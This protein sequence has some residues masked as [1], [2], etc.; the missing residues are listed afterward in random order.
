MILHE[1]AIKYRNG[2]DVNVVTI[3][4]EKNL[5]LDCKY[6]LEKVDVVAKS[7]NVLSKTVVLYLVHIKK[8]LK[9]LQFFENRDHD[10]Q[11]LVDINTD[12][13]CCTDRFN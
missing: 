4:L 9:M 7:L 8:W 12:L 11:N 5:L 13:L 3:L 6:F 2:F 1:L 10:N